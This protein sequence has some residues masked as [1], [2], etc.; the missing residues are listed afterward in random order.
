MPEGQHDLVDRNLLK[1]FDV[2]GPS[3]LFNHRIPMKVYDTGKHIRVE[4]GVF[5]V[6]EVLSQ[7]LGRKRLGLAFTAFIP[8]DPPAFDILTFVDP[9]LSH[10][11]NCIGTLHGLG[12]LR[13]KESYRV[14]SKRRHGRR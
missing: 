10:S 1:A 11:A 9:W 3:I 5:D 8:P 12:H 6:A 2:L 14:V 13:V 4:L 7:A